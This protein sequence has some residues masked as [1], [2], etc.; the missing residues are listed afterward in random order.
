M[1]D[2]SIK[3]NYSYLSKKENRHSTQPVAAH[4]DACAYF[5]N[6]IFIYYFAAQTNPVF[7]FTFIPQKLN[8]IHIQQSARSLDNC[9][10]KAE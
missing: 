10:F 3:F 2:N 6:M 5:F 9:F 4:V 7:T 8:L 1:T